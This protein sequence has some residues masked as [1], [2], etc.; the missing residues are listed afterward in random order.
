MPLYDYSCPSC[1]PFVAFRAIASRDTLQR[2]PNCA[3]AASR[4]ITA[5]NLALMPATTRKAYA[6]N[7]RS[8][9]EPRV[10]SAHTCSS[11]CG[12]GTPKGTAIKSKKPK[13]NQR[14]WMLGH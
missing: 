6:I 13:R 1:G 12:C 11:G 3:S 10:R 2:C 8:A 4:H 14:P 5:P 7:E 9:H